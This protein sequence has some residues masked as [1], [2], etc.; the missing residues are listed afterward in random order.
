MRSKEKGEQSTDYLIQRLGSK[1]APTLQHIDN[2][3]KKH[4]KAVSEALLP[5]EEVAPA[6]DKSELH[7]VEAILGERGRSRASKHYLVKYKGY[8][9]AWW[10]PA[11]NLNEC[12]RVLKAWEILPATQQKAKTEAALIANPE[13][14]NLV[15]DLRL[16]E[17]PAAKQLIKD[18]C[19]KLGISRKRL[20]A[21]VG[22][23]CCNTFT[24]LDSVNVV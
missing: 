15:M 8:S 4:E 21:V 22:S 14:I 20:R 23:P 5:E 18:I 24:Q 7:E 3:K 1:K 12:S 11:K 17:Q 19:I 13:E 16:Q 6:A 2:L 9:E 10:Q